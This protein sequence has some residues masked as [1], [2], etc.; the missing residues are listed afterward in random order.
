MFLLINIWSST[1]PEAEN[2][3]KNNKKH[4]LFKNKQIERRFKVTF[5]QTFCLQGGRGRSECCVPSVR[6]RAMLMS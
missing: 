1:L 6:F 3:N 2:R 5:L 4:R